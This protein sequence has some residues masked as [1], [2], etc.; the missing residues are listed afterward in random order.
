MAPPGD[1]D[2]PRLRA[3]IDELL[4]VSD[5]FRELWTRADIGYRTGILH[6]RHPIVGDLYLCRTRL[7]I[8]DS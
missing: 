7:S 1:L 5:R 8:P 2:D 3:L 4:A 6:M